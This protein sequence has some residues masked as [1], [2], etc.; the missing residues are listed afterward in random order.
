MRTPLI[1]VAGLVALVAACG[2]DDDPTES[3]TTDPPAEATPADTG[4][5][6]TAS[7]TTESESTAA[8]T[9]AEA[10]ATTIADASADT[11]TPADAVAFPVSIEHA[12]GTTEVPSAPERIVALSWSDSDIAVDLGLEPV[13]MSNFLFAAGG[14]APWL[15]AE[16]TGSPELVDT[17]STVELPYEQI[18]AIEPDLIIATGYYAI[19]DHYDTLSEIA[20]TIGQPLEPGWDQQTLAIGMAIGDV[21]A[22][23]ATVA[24]VT[25]QIS[26]LA[27]AHPE[28]EGAT[29]T[30]SLAPSP[31]AVKVVNAEGDAL[32]ELMNDLGFVLPDAVA[33]L[34]TTSSG[35]G[36]TD[37]S[38]EQ[39]DLID[40]DV[41]F[42]VHPGLTAT[43]AEQRPD[44]ESSPLFE[45]LDAV[46]RGGYVAL[47]FTDASGLRNPSPLSIPYYLDGLLG[48][49]LVAAVPA[50]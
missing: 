1:L 46:E 24:D 20:P 25:E 13:M 37:V 36:S 27:D 45:Q 35:A 7:E 40:A 38:I 2:S 41:V 5:G 48:E 44:I 12:Q 28:W 22:A 11:T 49:S 33:D 18:A 21:A 9:T 43:D 23:E 4:A 29:F 39:I 34:D 30:L 50:D 32:I 15:A 47:T 3:V 8:P 14:A 31:D 16:L 17:N 19:A 6:A 10:P 42:V 26:S